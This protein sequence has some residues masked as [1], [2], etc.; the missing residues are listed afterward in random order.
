MELAVETFA[1]D[2]KS[3]AVHM[4][5]VAASWTLAECGHKSGYDQND[6]PDTK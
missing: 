3:Y 1:Q 4:E 5:I 2:Q 6:N